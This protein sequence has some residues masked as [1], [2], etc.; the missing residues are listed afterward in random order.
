MNDHDR[1]QVTVSVIIPAYNSAKYV[2][3]AVSSALASRDVEPEIIVIDDGSTD[4]TWEALD[5]FGDVILKVRQDRG[6]PYRA[7]NLGASLARGEWL[8]F[9]DADDIWS[10]DKLSRQLQ[11]A[12]DSTG[13]IYTDRLNFGDIQHVA[14]RQSD[15]VTLWEGD[16]FK[17]LLLGNFITL[18]SVLI[19]KGWFD[20]LGG[21]SVE[22][23]GVQDWDLW[24]RYSAEGGLVKLCREPLTHYRWHSNQMSN[25]LE[26]R[27]GEREAVIRR[28]RA[29]ARGVRLPTSV[30]RRAIANSCELTAWHALAARRRGAAGWY[31]RA[32]Y[33]WPWN[34]AVY[35]GILKCC[36]GLS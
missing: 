20:R 8:A 11:L 25:D 9:L 4:D 12:D 13:L 35:K 32:A 14:E 5:R 15:S 24:L 27:A 29:T 19:R 3:E 2:V 36:I 30:I 7:R 18:S 26:T 21:F 1:R 33:H 23:R 31:L 17:P 28:I 16:V 34:P 6:G 10:P 22:H